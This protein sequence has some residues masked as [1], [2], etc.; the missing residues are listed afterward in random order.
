[1]EVMTSDGRV[2]LE[3]MMKISPSGGV[4]ESEL[5]HPL[6]AALK[7]GGGVTAAAL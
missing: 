4:Q 6:L 1:M 2:N 7:S 5:L 3:L